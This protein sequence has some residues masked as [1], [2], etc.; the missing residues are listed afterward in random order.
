MAAHPG[1]LDGIFAAHL[2]EHLSPDAVIALVRA[3][4]DALCPEGRLLLVTPNPHS[5][6]MQLQE[7]WIDLQHVR[8][9]APEAVRWIMHDAS[10]RDIETGENPLY[11]N[12]PDIAAS[13]PLH[14]SP[15]QRASR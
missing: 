15:P 12:A 5:I 1:E 9:Y 10:L 7:F 4:R 14:F 13:P 8:F 6:S 2:I 3:A 11:R